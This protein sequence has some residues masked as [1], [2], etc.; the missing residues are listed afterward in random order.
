[1]TR[2]ERERTTNAVLYFVERTVDC[3]ER[4]LFS[5][6]YLLD[7]SCFQETGQVVTGLS[8]SAAKSGPCPHVLQHALE[9]M[10]PEFGS[11][12]IRETSLAHNTQRQVFR[13][14]GKV[15]FDSDSFTTRHLEFMAIWTDKFRNARGREIDVSRYDNGA[16]QQARGRGIEQEI[17]FEETVSAD[18][19][20]RRDVL[21]IAAGVARRRT[22]LAKLA[23]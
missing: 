18:S 10:P 6:L 11:R 13:S 21:A 9:A 14:T 12:L 17:R 8:Y 22:H 7:V 1:M 16:W 20:N 19:P 2:A 4:K 15:P 3:T 5:L 23:A